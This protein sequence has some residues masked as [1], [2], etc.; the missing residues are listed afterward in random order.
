MVLKTGDEIMTRRVTFSLILLLAFLPQ[1]G[2]T[3][4]QTQL[5]QELERIDSRVLLESSP[6]ERGKMLAECGRKRIAQ[7]N[8]R[9]SREWQ[10]ITRGGQWEQFLKVR[11]EALRSS[12][13]DFPELSGAPASH[14]SK[15][16]SGDGFRVENLVFESR[17]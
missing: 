3:S 7:A 8:Q 4:A 13:G 10:A 2:C 5:P 9:S 16:L 14:V 17:P 12:L 1:L 6:E 11:L 15:T